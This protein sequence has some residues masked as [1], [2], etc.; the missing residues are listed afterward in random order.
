M[1]RDFDNILQSSKPKEAVS[2]S[3]VSVDDIIDLEEELSP[4]L[5]RTAVNHK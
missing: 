3:E 2:L 5:R 1:C 4:W